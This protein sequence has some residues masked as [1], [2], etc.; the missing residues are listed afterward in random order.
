MAIQVVFFDMGGTIQSFRY[1][2]ELRVQNA[3]LLRDCLE[4]GGIQLSL[5]DEELADVVTRG[6]DTYH[7]WNRE[8]MI[9]LPP[10]EVWKNVVF[11]DF[12]IAENLLSPIAEELT[13]LYETRFYVRKMRPEIPTVLETLTR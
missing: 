13:Y 7:K 10:F 6:M 9:E 1:T 3:P 2:R 12:A 8:S 4:K 5:S 11:K